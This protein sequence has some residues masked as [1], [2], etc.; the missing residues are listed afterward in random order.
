MGAP[1]W[2]PDPEK[3]FEET[4]R[5]YGVRPGD[6]GADEDEEF[7]RALLAAFLFESPVR[8]LVSGQDNGTALS[9]VQRALSAYLRMVSGLS[10]EI[11]ASDPPSTDGVRLFLPRAVPA[12]VEPGDHALY[13]AMGLVQLGLLRFGLLEGER[14]LTDLTRDWVLRSCYHLLASQVVLDRWAAAYPGLARDFDALRLMDKAGIMRINLTEVPREGMPAGFVP[15]YQG[16]TTCLNWDEPGRDGDPARQAVAAARALTARSDTAPRGEDPTPAEQAEARAVL[17]GQA[18]KLRQAFR[19]K[20]LGPPPLPYLIGILRPEW[21]LAHSA[22][23]LD[24]ENAWRA[25][26]TPLRQLREAQARAGTA[27]PAPE[28]P[29]PRRGLRARIKQRLGRALQGPGDP[30]ELRKAPAYGTLRDEHQQRRGEDAAGVPRWSPDTPMEELLAAADASLPQA[31][32]GTPHDEWND[33]DGVYELGATRV[34]E[35]PAPVGPLSS[36]DKLVAANGRRIAEI[37]RQFEKLRLEERWLHGQIDGSQLDLDR[38]ITAF[39]DITAGQDP[40]PRVFMRYQRQRQQVAILTLVDLSGSTQGHVV[41]LEQEALVLFAEGLRTLRFPHAFYGFHND[42]PQR[43]WLERIKAFEDSYDETVFKR[44]A[45]LQPSGATRMGAFVRHGA[46]LLD[47]QP[48]PRRVLLVLSDG[49]PEDRDPYRGA[50]GLRDTAMAVQEAAKLGVHC[51]CI[52]L[53][54]GHDAPDYLEKVFGAGCFLALKK[55]EELP[56]RLPEVFARLIR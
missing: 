26:P 21:I 43:C 13:R 52:S 31:E 38:A 12:P 39:C 15:L 55:V 18:N 36:Y 19:S 23:D 49:R 42:G 24:A 11:A 47:K 44:M 20:R 28:L 27:E 54:A 29:K 50:Y 40:D 16:L 51:F 1:T 25:G 53:D 46:L 37:R 33:A 2:P 14:L 6:I 48:Q 9:Q 8:Q 3:A 30:E 34:I 45:N 4:A 5:E 35:Q 7:E 56:Q 22:R 32:E 41:H 10:V 17:L